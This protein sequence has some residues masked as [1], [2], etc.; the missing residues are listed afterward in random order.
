MIKPIKPNPPNKPYP[1]NKNQKVNTHYLD[2]DKLFFKRKFIMVSDEG[3]EVEVPESQFSYGEGYVEIESLSPS[4]EDFAA[5]A[6]S[7]PLNKIH[8]SADVMYSDGV[9]E[10]EILRSLKLYYTTP[11]N[12]SE[13]LTTYQQQLSQYEKDLNH[14]K[15]VLMPEYK[16]QLAIY[17]NKKDEQI[18][19]AKKKQLEA[20]LSKLNKKVAS[21][22]V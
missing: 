5:L 13:A 18:L 15:N 9:Q 10:G 22:H 7:I 14:Y 12:Y 17:N 16:K 2:A 21:K 11:F 1:P 20:E 4:L 19:I 3:D 6:P 8:L